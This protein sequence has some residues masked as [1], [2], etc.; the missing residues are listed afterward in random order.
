MHTLREGTAL[1][2][3]P[4]RQCLSRPGQTFWDGVLEIHRKLKSDLAG[5]TTPRG[6]GGQPMSE[7]KSAP[8]GRIPEFRPES[9]FG[10]TFASGGE[11]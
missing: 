1:A 2:P 8:E 4:E 3:C 9:Y 6:R 7:Q 11:R 5:A 10:D